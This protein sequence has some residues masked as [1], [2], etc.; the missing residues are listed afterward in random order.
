MLQN[1]RPITIHTAYVW[2]DATY[3]EYN[4]L[5]LQRYFD[6]DHTK[7]R[8][9]VCLCTPGLIL[10]CESFS[11][12][13]TACLICIY[14]C[15]YTRRIYPKWV[16]AKKGPAYSKI[17]LGKYTPYVYVFGSVRLYMFDPRADVVARRQIH[18][19]RTMTIWDFDRI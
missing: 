6:D 11:T 15:G 5:H 1:H 14:D 19:T 13:Y 18:E 3:I 8:A 4:Q 10:K 12:M 7:R 17:S 16:I 2:C 9:R